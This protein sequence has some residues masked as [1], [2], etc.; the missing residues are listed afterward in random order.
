MIPIKSLERQIDEMV[1]TDLDYWV[2]AKCPPPFV[3]LE[4][5][6]GE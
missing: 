5:M 6:D 1:E 2:E 3:Q 4:L